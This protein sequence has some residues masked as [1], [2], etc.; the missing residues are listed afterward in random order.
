[1]CAKDNFASS[2]TGPVLLA[3][4]A[5]THVEVD[6]N[7]SCSYRIEPLHGYLKSLSNGVIIMVTVRLNRNKL[8]LAMYFRLAKHS[9]SHINSL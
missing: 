8:G 6:I 1:M 5:W 9:L 4:P 7:E 2:E 3:K